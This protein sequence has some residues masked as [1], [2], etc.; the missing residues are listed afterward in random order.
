MTHLSNSVSLQTLCENLGNNV[1]D[2]GFGSL[3]AYTDKSRMI[4]NELFD[5]KSLRKKDALSQRQK[6]IADFIISKGD[7]GADFKEINRAD[8]LLSEVMYLAT[9][10]IIKPSE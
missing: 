3:C 6:E 10:G 8:F 1:S 2:S 5:K 7:V 4:I 9:I